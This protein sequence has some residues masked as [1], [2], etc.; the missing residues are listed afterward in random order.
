MKAE[1]KQAIL[2]RAARKPSFEVVPEHAIH[3]FDHIIEMNSTAAVTAHP[4]DYWGQVTFFKA[5]ILEDTAPTLRGII[6]V[7]FHE[8]IASL[9]RGEMAEI[10]SDDPY[11][12]QSRPHNPNAE[13]IAQRDAYMACSA[14]LA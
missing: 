10:D 6:S 14:S 11:G 13:A 9:L 3:M 4:D 1:T 12:F 8:Y 2:V 7:Y 5:A